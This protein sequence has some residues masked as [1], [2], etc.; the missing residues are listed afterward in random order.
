[1]KVNRNLWFIIFGFSLASCASSIA[2]ID[3]SEN[4][5]KAL[6]VIDMQL[7]YIGENAKFSIEHNQIENLI[8]I[9]NEITKVKLLL[10]RDRWDKIYYIDLSYNEY[11][12]RAC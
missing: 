1:M 11:I 10:R 6:L 12:I 2:K 8:M 7:D 5:Q 4:T 3:Y 9:T